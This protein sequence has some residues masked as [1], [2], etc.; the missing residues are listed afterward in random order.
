[1]SKGKNNRILTKTVLTSVT[2]IQMAPLIINWCYLLAAVSQI[3]AWTSK[4]CLQVSQVK[5]IHDVKKKKNN[6]N[7]K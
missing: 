2:M 3:S 4:K 5:I 7:Y 6:Y 1:M